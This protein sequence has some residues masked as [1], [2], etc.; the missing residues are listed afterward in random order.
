MFLENN[1]YSKTALLGK[2]VLI[3]GGGGGIGFEAS[4]AFS[5]M[6]AKVI[7]A[8]IDTLKGKQA[9]KL[10]N[11]EYK[12]ENVDFFQIDISDEKQIDKLHEYISNR[13]TKLD[14]I[15]NNAA[16]VPMG[17]IEA[18]SI[19]DWDLSYAVNLRAPVLLAQKFLP[20]M[21]N[22]GGIIV[23]VPSTGAQPFMGAYEIFKSAQVELCNIISE[24]VSEHI[25][26]YSIAPGFVKTDTAVKAV[27]VV[28]SS[29]GITSE[30]FFKAHEEYI[31]DAELAGV[32]YAVSVV[33]AKKYNGLE[34]LSSQALEDEGLIISDATKQDN[35]PHQVDYDRLILLFTDISNTF[36]DQYQ[37][38]QKKNLFQ[39]QFILSDFK[40]Q[41][42]IPAESFKK[43]LETLQSHIQNQK[44]D[45]LLNSKD[46]F[47]KW[48][49]F[50]KHQKKLLQS[51]EK[52]ATQLANDTKLLNSWIDTLQGIIDVI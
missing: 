40:K 31:L 34:I 4:R 32:G 9:Q 35:I 15:I 13:Y 14:V 20:F 2:T 11:N 26:T 44:W 27:E 10:I 6:G 52:N 5:Y 41:M 42:G 19:S 39:K 17:A 12:N 3:T 51:Y 22:T 49:S 43:Q 24:E 8:E 37:S 28:A 38:W 36:L 23:F 16:V 50:Y 47:I 7:I 30:D 48:Q 29:M 1:N 46:M 21:R 33:N 18:V 25:I 45:S